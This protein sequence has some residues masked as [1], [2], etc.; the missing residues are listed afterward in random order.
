MR[1]LLGSGGFSTPERREPFLRATREHFGAVGR[2]LFIPY[3]VDDHD[4]YVARMVEVG[5]GAGYELVGIHSLP[6]PVKAV[7]EAEAI[8]VGGGN[9]FRLL[10]E[11]QRQEG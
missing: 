8:S 4:R 2:V 3:A 9:T 6:D 7:R 5:F 11:L 10:K 1:I